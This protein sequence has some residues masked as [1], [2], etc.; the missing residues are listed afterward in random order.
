MDTFTTTGGRPGRAVRPATAADAWAIRAL[1]A[2]LHEFNASLEPR[3]ALAEGWERLL[4]EQ[5]E[6]ECTTS[7]GVTLVAW[8]GGVP[9]GLAMAA[10]HTDST[11]FRHRRWA[12]LTALYVVPAARGGDVADRLLAAA[13]AWARS[14]GDDEVRLYVTAANE[15]ARRFYASAGFRPLQEIWTIGPDPAGGT[16]ADE[17]A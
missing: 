3:F 8:D 6:R 5:L 16:V 14:R 1:F 15:R 10:E 2:A 13:L 7:S 12:E 11:M 9:V 4:I 17:A